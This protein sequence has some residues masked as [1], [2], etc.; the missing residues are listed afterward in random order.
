MA[1]SRLPDDMLARFA[2]R[3]PAYD[4]ENRFFTE[5]FEDLRQAGYLKMVVPTELGGAGMT[6]EEVMREQRRLAYHAP[7]D[8]VA[9]NMHLYWTGS[10]PTCSEPETTR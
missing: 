8:A 1:D 3:A 2:E 4:R 10:R 9:V 7:A 5:D 6:L